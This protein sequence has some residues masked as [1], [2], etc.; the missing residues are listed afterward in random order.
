MKIVLL[1]PNG[2]IHIRKKGREKERPSS[3]VGEEADQPTFQ[4]WA[5]GLG[6]EH[7]CPRYKQLWK[8]RC[9]WQWG[10]LIVMRLVTFAGWLCSPGS[11][12]LT[13][14]FSTFSHIAGSSSEIRRPRPTPLI[15]DSEGL[16]SRLVSLRV[17]DALRNYPWA[18][19]A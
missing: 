6:V 18:F 12:A 2:S 11:R 7:K 16:G 15:K 8:P 1:R 9:G 19:S 10:P 4:A 14:G 17:I 5:G 13:P 3:V